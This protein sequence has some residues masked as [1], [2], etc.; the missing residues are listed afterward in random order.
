MFPD[1]DG[2]VGEWRNT[3]EGVRWGSVTE[4]G[5]RG[6]DARCARVGYVAD[7]SPV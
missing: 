4:T 5:R 2:W 3:R 6:C 1:R 7:I